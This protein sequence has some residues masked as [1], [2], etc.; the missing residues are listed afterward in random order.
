MTS[1][2][3]YAN[4]QLANFISACFDLRNIILLHQTDV[5]WLLYHN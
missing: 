1:S 3:H 5:I 2:N 4:S